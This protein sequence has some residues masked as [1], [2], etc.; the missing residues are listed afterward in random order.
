M[1]R[2]FIRDIRLSQNWRHMTQFGGVSDRSVNDKRSE[3]HSGH[4]NS[5]SNPM[6]TFSCDFPSFLGLKRIPGGSRE[7]SLHDLVKF[8]LTT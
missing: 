5:F 6:V 7:L 4:E 1:R 2:L 8:T 3:D